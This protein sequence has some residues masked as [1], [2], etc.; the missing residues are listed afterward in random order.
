[1]REDSPLPQL[2]QRGRQEEGEGCLSNCHMAKKSARR[3]GTLGCGHRGMS[4]GE[5]KTLEL[6]SPGFGK[7]FV[8]VF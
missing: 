6:R 7:P 8:R 2:S 4:P 1:M 5:A 3:P